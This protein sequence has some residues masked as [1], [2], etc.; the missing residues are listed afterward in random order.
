MDL[1]VAGVAVVRICVSTQN[2]IHGAVRELNSILGSTRPGCASHGRARSIKRSRY[3][4]DLSAV[5]GV[6][7]DDTTLGGVAP[8]GLRAAIGAQPVHQPALVKV[9]C[10]AEGWLSHVIR[11]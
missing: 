9:Q 5:G 6:N 10:M 7:D 3:E 11:K 4:T 2:V 8:V 1:L